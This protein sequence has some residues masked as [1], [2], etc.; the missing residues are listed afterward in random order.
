MLAII[1]FFKTYWKKILVGLGLIIVLTTVAIVYSHCKKQPTIDQETIQKIND[2]NEQKRLEALKKTVTDNLDV[3][4][5]THDQT[6]LDNLEIDQK[7][8]EIDKKVA[9]LDKKV[10]EAK[11]QGHDVTQAELECLLVPANC[12]Q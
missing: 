2:K 12:T 5:D 8:K 1:L 4:K 11:K 10:E 9:E 6:T 7:N 3:I